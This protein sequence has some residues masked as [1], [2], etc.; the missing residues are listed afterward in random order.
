MLLAVPTGSPCV[1][2]DAVVGVPPG[3]IVA[4]PLAELAALGRQRA[5]GGKRRKGHSSHELPLEQTL[6]LAEE[7]RQQPLDGWFLG[8]GVADCQPGETLSPPVAVALPALTARLAETLGQLAH[9]EEA[10]SC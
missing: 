7:L 5:G 8:I 6:A 4:R 2:V 1:V 3:T 10:L 9:P